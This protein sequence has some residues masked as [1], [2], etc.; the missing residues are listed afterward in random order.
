MGAN[1]HFLDSEKVVYD[2]H[3]TTDDF[4]D[5]IM[6]LNTDDYS[7]QVLS[8]TTA[9]ATNHMRSKRGEHEVV[10]YEQVHQSE[11]QARALRT[12]SRMAAATT[13]GQQTQIIA[14][15][16]Q[17]DDSWTETVVAPADGM[18]NS[19]PVVTIQ[20][21]GKAA[22]IWQRG[23]IEVID[24]SISADSV[25]NTAMNG[26][27]VL[28]HYDG[29]KWSQPIDLFP[30]SKDLSMQRYDLMMR[31]DTVLVGAAMMEHPLDTAIMSRRFSYASVSTATGRVS[32]IEE[33]LRPT[34][35]FMN[36]VGHHAV[37]AMIYEKNDST[38]D[39]YVK[40]LNM[41][42]INDGLTGSDIGARFCS[43]SRV[44][45]ICDRSAN[46]LDDF[47]VLWT[48]MNNTARNDDGTEITTN[49]VK[50]M[51]NASR[52]SLQ[53]TPH[54]TVPITLGADRDSLI[55]TDFDGFLDDTSIKV[56]YSLADPNS[57]DAVIMGNEKFF[58]NSFEYDV[59]YT[60]EALL[61]NDV[62]PVNIIVS[63][64]GTSPIKSVLATINGE[65]YDIP[66]SYVHP[67]QRR[68]F[69]LQYPI[70]EGFDGYL[71]TTASVKYDNVFR[72]RSHP[73]RALSLTSQFKTLPP[74]HADLEDVELRLIGQNVED[75]VNTFLVEITDNS[76][77]HLDKDDAIRVGV[78]PHPT[79][80]E[81]ITDEAEVIVRP[82]DFHDYGSNRKAY[83]TI[84]VSNV[85]ETQRAYLNLHTYN[86]AY[87]GDDPEEAI[88]P[89]VQDNAHYILLVPDENPT[90]I[91]QLR[92][93]P[94]K[95]AISVR[96]AANGVIVSGIEKDTHIRVFNT[97]GILI[98]RDS[99]TGSDVNIPL[100][101]HGAYVLSAGK[102][103]IKFTY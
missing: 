52:I 54:V 67:C 80:I 93:Q 35:F 74:M 18:V 97:E 79:I 71:A 22:C 81:P 30:V 84:T 8:D 83:A 23:S 87:S 16:H 62:I 9:T 82:T 89:N 48:E 44:K 77:R 59:E 19:H 64:T 96:Q 88:I 24:P 70:P 92:A 65:V 1:P 90:V 72:S 61:T 11:A 45:I 63:N 17:G 73:R 99:G 7:R 14:K 20:D 58:S 78:Y 75:G 12:M 42:G 55:I 66:D 29:N 4:D 41:N 36:R 43:P 37:I 51:L 5:R 102:E 25:N 33:P 2:D 57:G 26:H 98:V 76:I 86:T 34:E 50:M 100:R 32:T 85:Q 60:R 49:Q 95:G 38:R 31:G 27:L 47:A 15:I 56:V 13:M 21:D 28:S 103:I 94:A 91:E 68:T 101:H 40:S 3:A 53:P 46:N 39:I 10:V 69:A 6:V